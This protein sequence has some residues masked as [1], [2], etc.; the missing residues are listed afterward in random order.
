MPGYNTIPGSSGGGGSGA[1]TFVASVHMSTYNRSWAQAGTAGYYGIYSADGSSGY[2]YF[3]GTSMTT[4]IS[5]NRVVNVPHSFTSINIVAPQ[6]DLVT[7]YKAKVKST[8]TFA[9]PLASMTINPAVLIASGNFALPTN[10]TVP[11]ADIAVV[12]AGGAAGGGHGATHGGGGGGGGGNVINLTDY[13]IYGTTIVSIGFGGT[14]IKTGRGGSGGQ[15]AFGP[16]YALGGGGGGGWDTRAASTGGNGGGGGAGGSEGTGAAGIT[17]ISSSGLGSIGSPVFRG[18]YSGGA[19][20]T[21]TGIS[22][23]GGGGGGVLANG[24]NGVANGGGNGGAGWVSSITGSQATFGAG[25]YGSDPN[26]N[27]GSGWSGLAYGCGGQSTTNGH[28]S[29]TPVGSNGLNGVV[30]VRFYTP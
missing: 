21:S 15:S 17:Q 26:S 19:G 5:M 11:F 25:G 23:R 28:S 4:G 14:G 8:T 9:N 12:G 22:S 24:T 10:A 20:N 18:G 30:V 7:L 3:V 29:D 1:L 13:P 2:A 27:G 6:G 16:V